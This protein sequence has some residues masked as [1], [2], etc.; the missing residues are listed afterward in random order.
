MIT[1]ILKK[2]K[3]LFYVE[4][5]GGGGGGG[6]TWGWVNDRMKITLRPK[7]RQVSFFIGTDFEK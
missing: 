4:E 1:N 3:N 2:K 7:M 6:V 5:G